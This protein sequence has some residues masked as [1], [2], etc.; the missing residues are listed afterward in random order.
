MRQEL[1][2]TIG[3]CHCVQEQSNRREIE[4]LQRQLQSSEAIVADF[5]NTLQQRDSMLETLRAK[6]SIH[7]SHKS[8][9]GFPSV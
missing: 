8:I 9:T 7:S 1:T 3:I 4:D 5:Q 2:L 6:V